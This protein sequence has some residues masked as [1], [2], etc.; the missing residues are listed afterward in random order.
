MKR[1][2]I[3]SGGAAV[4]LLGIAGCAPISQEGEDVVLT[5]NSPAEGSSNGLTFN[6]EIGID[7]D[8]T[9]GESSCDPSNVTFDV[10]SGMI[11]AEWDPFACT[12]E[13]GVP[14]RGQGNI[15]LFVDG[16]FHAISYDTTVEVDLTP[17]IAFALYDYLYA[18]DADLDGDGVS[19]YDLVDLDGDGVGDVADADGDGVEDLFS[20]CNFYYPDDNLHYASTAFNT[21]MYYTAEDYYGVPLY[22]IGTGQPLDPQPSLYD[23]IYG[24]FGYQPWL[25]FD[26]NGLPFGS[27]DGDS[28]DEHLLS[29]ELHYDNHELVYGANRA[30][31]V[32][33]AMNLS[34]M[35]A[36]WCGF[37]AVFG[38]Y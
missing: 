11:Q 35:P 34:D 29:A 31:T 26:Y 30:R 3:S 37:H 23:N 14:P 18:E 8:F 27:G 19:D 22:D 20:Y 16:I 17:K 12:D 21:D 9:L 33:G 4:L 6:A 2:W 28:T 24:Y 10:Y 25:N 15:Q 13:N 5:I 38:P 32:L 7:G 1:I 36:D